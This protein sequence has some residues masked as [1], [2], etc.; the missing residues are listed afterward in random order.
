MEDRILMERDGGNQSM[1]IAQEARIPR[2][3]ESAPDFSARSTEGMIHLSDYTSRGKY[4]LLFSHP[5]DF[6]P[7]CST[8]FIALARAWKRFD[9]L[10]V[11][12]IGVSFDSVNAHI[13]WFRDLEKSAGIEIKF[14]VVADADHAIANL[15]GLVHPEASRTS[16][17]RAVYA[18]DP[19]RTIRAILFYSPQMGRG[20][21]EL[22][23]VF[24]GL[25]AIDRTHVSLPCDWTPGQDVV[26][27]APVTLADAAKRA[28]VGSS[29]LKVETWYL[30]RKE[31]P[32][33]ELRASVPQ[34]RLISDI[35]DL[36][37]TSKP[38]GKPSESESGEDGAE[39]KLEDYM[40]TSESLKLRSGNL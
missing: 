9:D 37:A 4:V 7:V 30:S 20:V 12:L 6:S 18:I 26:A 16:P 29:G 2:I 38:E 3:L 13:A 21:E 27:P 25:Q 35:A 23:R 1:S 31:L 10:G 34:L 39:L 11:Q 15:Y 36:V 14:P 33:E 40:L 28:N 24:E 8:E 17:V 5:A 22:I 32:V 19:N